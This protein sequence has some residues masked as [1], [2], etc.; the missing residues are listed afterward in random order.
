MDDFEKELWKA[1]FLQRTN[2]GDLICQ[3]EHWACEV[4]KAYRESNEKLDA[5]KT[6]GLIENLNKRR[7]AED[8]HAQAMAKREAGE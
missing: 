3:A 6:N 4:V 2:G 5:L 8:R 1:A 7:E